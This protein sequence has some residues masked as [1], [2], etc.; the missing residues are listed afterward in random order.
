MPDLSLYQVGW[1]TQKL[2]DT[3]SVI[4]LRHV[5]ND[6]VIVTYLLFVLLEL[7]FLNF[8]QDM[9]EINDQLDKEKIISIDEDLL[10]RTLFLVNSK[11]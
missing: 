11:R 10:P 6:K 7:L 1:F 5:T 8:F 3:F 4:L 9:N 2:A